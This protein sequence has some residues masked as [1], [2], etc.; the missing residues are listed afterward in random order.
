M[1]A[2]V[3][4]CFFLEGRGSADSHRHVRSVSISQNHDDGHLRLKRCKWCSLCDKTPVA[5][6]ISLKRTTQLCALCA[7]TCI[8]IHPSG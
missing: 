5:I 4:F 6:K 1:Q 7:L 8:D 2:M 3:D